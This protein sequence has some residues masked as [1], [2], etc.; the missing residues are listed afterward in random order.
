MTQPFA[1]SESTSQ[2]KY[3]IIRDFHIEFNQLMKQLVNFTSLVGKLYKLED[4]N[5]AIEDMRSGLIAGRV[6]IEL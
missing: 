5:N 3:Y 1:V 2:L 6:M 4:I